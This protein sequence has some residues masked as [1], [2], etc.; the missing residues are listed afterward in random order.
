MNP[1]FFWLITAILLVLIR[2]AEAQHAAK[3]PQM[4]Y[5]AAASLSALTARIEAFKQGFGFTKKPSL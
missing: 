5:L 2:P 3:V 1:K 4:R